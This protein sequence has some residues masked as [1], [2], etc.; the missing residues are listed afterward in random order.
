MA[1]G[2]LR[3][4]RSQITDRIGRRVKGVN[5]IGGVRVKS[6]E[7]GSRCPGAAVDAVLYA[8]DFLYGNCCGRYR[9]NAGGRNN[10]SF[11][12]AACACGYSQK[13]DCKNK[14]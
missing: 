1:F 14:S 13:A 10:L 11:V 5:R 6:G 2:R 9:C 12:S 7:Y 3:R 8:A 4:I